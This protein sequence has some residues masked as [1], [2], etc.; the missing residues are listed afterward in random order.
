[1][2]YSWGEFQDLKNWIFIENLLQIVL[3][4][5]SDSNDQTLF[6]SKLICIAVEQHKM[7]SFI[8]QALE[9]LSEFFVRN[10]ENLSISWINSF[11]H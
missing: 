7:K 5:P 3:E 8:E 9:E 1:M 2:S 10:F 11:S 4:S 6:V